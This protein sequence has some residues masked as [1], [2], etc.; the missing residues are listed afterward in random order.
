[1]TAEELIQEK[2]DE[3][4]ST[5]YDCEKATDNINKMW[6]FLKTLN[7]VLNELRIGV[8]GDEGQHIF[9]A[10]VLKLSEDTANVLMDS[11]CNLYKIIFNYGFNVKENTIVFS[12]I[13]YYKLN[14][15][16][17]ISQ[18]SYGMY[19]C[20]EKI[21]NGF[22]DYKKYKIQ[23]QNGVNDVM[24]GI[25]EIKNIISSDL[26]TLTT[27]FKDIKA[28]DDEMDRIKVRMQVH[29]DKIDEYNRTLS[30]I[31]DKQRQLFVKKMNILQ[32][33]A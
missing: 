31:K 29:Y 6:S 18:Y 33:F 24:K 25:E 3:Q 10:F 15:N 5:M 13:N 30:T 32:D 11:K 14:V 28:L 17:V 8:S 20:D 12:S 4:R 27:T 26:N 16:R 1:M 23:I 19:Q 21:G 2:I 9:C 7:V 22:L